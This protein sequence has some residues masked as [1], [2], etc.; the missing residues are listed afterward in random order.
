MTPSYTVYL[1]GIYYTY[2]SMTDDKNMHE[3]APTG[4]VSSTGKPGPEVRSDQRFY[5]NS[6]KY[7]AD[8]NQFQR[9]WDQ[10]VRVQQKFERRPEALTRAASKSIISTDVLGHLLADEIHR[11]DVEVALP[12]AEYG[13]SDSWLVFLGRNASGRRAIASSE[14]EMEK[15]SEQIDLVQT[16]PLERLKEKAAEGFTFTTSIEPDQ[17]DDLYDLWGSTFGWTSEQ[18]DNFRQSIA[19]EKQGNLEDRTIWFAGVEYGGKLIGASMGQKLVMKGE[20][21]IS[22]ECVESTEWRKKPDSPGNG[23]TPSVLAGLH[24]QILESF[25]EKKPLIFAE[26]NIFAGANSTGHKAGLQ[27][28]QREVAIGE[29]VYK[30]PQIL[31]QNVKIGDD[32]EVNAPYRDFVVESLTKEGIERYYTPLQ[33]TEILS[34]F[35]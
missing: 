13:M 5:V 20:G 29:R 2:K 19:L 7:S 18:V 21:D 3:Q 27:I 24:A 16:S 30:V 31:K 4:I 22:L 6:S 1:S 11:K 15:T 17:V 23:L 26:C 12:L 32:V 25:G 8:A 9:K 14:V 10:T 35:K 28:P 34:Y 33:R